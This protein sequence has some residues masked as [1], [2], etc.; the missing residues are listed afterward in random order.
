MTRSLSA[1]L[2]TCV[3]SI[4]GH[5]STKVSILCI[6]TDYDRCRFCNIARV[7]PL[8]VALQSRTCFRTQLQSAAEIGVVE[9]F[10]STA[11]RPL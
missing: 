6:T 8:R 3:T 4:I 10:L 11:S 9:G 7:A 2:I 5:L 1:L